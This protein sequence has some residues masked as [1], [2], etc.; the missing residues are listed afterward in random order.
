MRLLATGAFFSDGVEHDRLWVNCIELLATSARQQAGLNVLIDMQ[1]Y[2]TL[3]A[4]YALALGALAA[5]RVNSIA[6]ALA[7]VSVREYSETVPVAV[8]AASW[9]VLAGDTL[10]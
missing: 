10:P 2:P 8:A 6:R 3:L 9:K 4:L 7:E 1:Q 5:N